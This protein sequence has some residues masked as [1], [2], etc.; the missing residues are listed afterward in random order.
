[1]K[2]KK[3]KKRKPAQ[4]PENKWRHR[5]TFSNIALPGFDSM[6]PNETPLVDRLREATKPVFVQA[7]PGKWVPCKPH[8]KH[9]YM[10]ISYWHDNGDG[11]Y[12][13]YPVTER[14]VKL[15]SSVATKLGFDGQY[16]TLR[17]LAEA[18]FIET[19]KVAPGLTLIN[20]DSYFNHLKRTSED[21]EFWDRKGRNFQTYKLVII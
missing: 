5:K 21:P 8:E 19:I 6:V 1:M 10:T 14:L 9:P 3:H 7:A 4:R 18:G 13:P 20:V 2:S 17:R 15:D 11:T 12:T 16:N